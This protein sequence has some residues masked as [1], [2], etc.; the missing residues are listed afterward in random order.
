[1]GVG[2]HHP[3]PNTYPW[4]EKEKDLSKIRKVTLIEPQ[5]PG[6]HVYSRFALPRLGLPILGAVLKKKGINVSIYCQDFHPIDYDEVLS[7]DLVGISTTTSTAPEGYRIAQRVKEA[8]I[9]VVMGG[10]HVT[11]QSEEAINY[12]DFCVRG[13]GEYTFHELIDAIDSG[14]GFGGIKGQKY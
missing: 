2:S 5:P 10:S 14:S 7:S 1:M 13:E 4:S 9:P 3:I 11:F 12:S 6:Y 8:G